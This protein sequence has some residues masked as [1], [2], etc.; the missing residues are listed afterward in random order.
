MDWPGLLRVGLTGLGLKP[1]EFWALTPAEFAALLGV[2]PSAVPM[3]RG[4]LDELL[5]DYPDR[6]NGGGDEVR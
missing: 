6:F 2:D 3:G 4:R 5:R 1:C